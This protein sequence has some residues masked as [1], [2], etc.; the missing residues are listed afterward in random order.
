MVRGNISYG[1]DKA[2]DVLPKNYEKE[3]C[4]GQEENLFQ[5]RLQKT[6]ITTQSIKI[7]IW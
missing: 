1:H 6:H 2:K 5:S 4:Y 7:L 3:M